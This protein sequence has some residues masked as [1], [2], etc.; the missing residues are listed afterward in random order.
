[1]FSMGIGINEGLPIL[2]MPEISRALQEIMLE[3]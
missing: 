3:K 2:I 1:M